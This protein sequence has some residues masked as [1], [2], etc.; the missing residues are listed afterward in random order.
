[1]GCEL[2]LCT[3]T[4]SDVEPTG[5]ASCKSVEIPAALGEGITKEHNRVHDCCSHLI[6]RVGPVCT[7]VWVEGRN[8]AGGA[9]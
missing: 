6:G 3:E 9:G 4:T 5:E 2:H 1:M 8:A 7:E